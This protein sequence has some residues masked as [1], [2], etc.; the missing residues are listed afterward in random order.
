MNASVR[1]L[2]QLAAASGGKPVLIAAG[3]TGGHV[4]PGLS[5]AE[6]I[7][8]LGLQ[9][10][11]VGTPW[12]LESRLVPEAGI[13]IEWVSVSGLR[14]KGKLALLAAPWRLVKACAQAMAIIRRRNPYVVLGLGG[15]AS[16][17]A[18]L[19][20]WLLRKPLVVHEQNAVPGLTNKCLSRL[21]QR[22]LEA[23]PGAF[24]PKRQALDVGNPVRQEIAA[25]APPT[26]RL[27]G[28]TGP[29]RLLVIGGSQ[30]ARV[31]NQVVPAAVRD[32]FEEVDVW[33][34]TGV[35]DLEITQ[36][37][38]DGVSARVHAF[39][40]NM[41]EAYTWADLVICRSGAMTV[42]ELAAVGMPSILVPYPTAVDD[43]Q[44]KNG[45]YLVKDGAAVMIQQKDLTKERLSAELQRI[46]EDRTILFAMA[47]KARRLGRTD[48]AEQVAGVCLEVGR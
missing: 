20:A 46:T 3:G 39:I 22:T 12:G 5:V 6:V 8:G 14:G 4:F 45:E 23:F 41:A 47:E 33:H 31:L 9:V 11:W 16:G 24:N 43:H 27:A 18:G 7:R 44:T 26:V 30:G 28:R 29:I 17:P 2:R 40:H 10:I 38:Y 48:A 13:E 34:Q 15:F 42:A 25:V 1:D 21:A 35:T 19:A 32:M 37:A 36:Q